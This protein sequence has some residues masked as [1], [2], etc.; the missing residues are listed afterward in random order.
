MRRFRNPNKDLDAL[1]PAYKRS[2]AL[3]WQKWRLY[4]GALTVAMPRLILLCLIVVILSMCVNLFLVGHTKGDPITGCRKFF[5]R[6]AF[7]SAAYLQ[8]LSFFTILR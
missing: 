3:Q 2:D 6:M 7:M 1:Y 5:M 8:A 4:P